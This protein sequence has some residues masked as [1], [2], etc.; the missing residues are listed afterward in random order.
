MI[1]INLQNER[2]AEHDAST[3]CNLSTCVWD[4]FEMRLQEIQSVLR[5]NVKARIRTVDVFRIYSK[6][7]K[8]GYVQ[9][10]KSS[11]GS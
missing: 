9:R 11:K 4:L 10:E 7:G 8:N 3:Q 5:K 6:R 1:F 2:I